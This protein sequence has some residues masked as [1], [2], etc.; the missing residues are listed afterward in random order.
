VRYT[1]VPFPRL[2]Y[3]ENNKVSKCK[4]ELNWIKALLA[5]AKIVAQWAVYFECQINKK[6]IPSDCLP[7]GECSKNY[8]GNSRTILG[9]ITSY[10][11]TKILLLSFKRICVHGMGLKCCFSTFPSTFHLDYNVFITRHFIRRRPPFWCWETL[12]FGVQ[13]SGPIGKQA[14]VLECKISINFPL[15]NTRDIHSSPDALTVY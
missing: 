11:F 6:R 5:V 7:T 9:D 15:R 4:Y 12:D 14:S 10:V 3:K 2:N 13:L 8:T 1:R